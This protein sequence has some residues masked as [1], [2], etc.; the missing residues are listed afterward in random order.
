[1]F[2]YCENLQVD[3]SNWTT[4]KMKDISYAFEGCEKL[5]CDFNKWEINKKTTDIDSA[6]DGC[7]SL[8]NIPDWY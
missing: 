8:T 3:L 1:M 7:I 5:N 4:K 2:L 6:F